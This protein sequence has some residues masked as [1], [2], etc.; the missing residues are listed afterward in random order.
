MCQILLK[1][2]VIVTFVLAWSRA[3]SV[4]RRKQ[5]CFAEWSTPYNR[6]STKVVFFARIFI[7]KPCITCTQLMRKLYPN[8]RQPW[9]NFFRRVVTQALRGK[10]QKYFLFFP[11]NHD[12]E[13]SQTQFMTKLGDNEA[14]HFVRQGVAVMLFFR[15]I[16]QIL[17]FAHFMNFDKG[18]W[19]PL[20]TPL[21]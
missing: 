12:K 4:F 11:A 5:K 2:S 3:V 7:W 19:Q 20:M 15:K 10:H 1:E 8:L 21:V 6:P 9:L 17:L 13:K 14:A 18:V 16:G